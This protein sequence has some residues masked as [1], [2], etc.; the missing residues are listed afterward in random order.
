MTKEILM[1]L[2]VRADVRDA[3]RVAADMKGSTMSGLLNQYI[4][5]TIRDVQET[6]PEEFR[7]KLR[8]LEP[9]ELR[10]G[11]ALPAK[12]KT[13]KGKTKKK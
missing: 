8:E 2:R 1:T 4:V 10:I 7:L 6:Y 9:T 12:P 11:K 5:R 13:N 3:F